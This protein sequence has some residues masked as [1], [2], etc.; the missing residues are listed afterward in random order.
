MG[1]HKSAAGDDGAAVLA[2]LQ[3]IYDVDSDSALARALGAKRSTVGAWRARNTVPSDVCIR[4][5]GEKK[6]SLHWLLGGIGEQTISAAGREAQ[7]RFLENIIRDPA[8]GAVTYTSERG[9]SALTRAG[10]QVAARAAEREIDLE[11]MQDC[12][13]ALAEHAAKSQR[14]PKPEKFA[15]VCIALYE[16]SK[17]S[18][19]M[20]PANS[21]RRLLEAID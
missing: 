8:V 6:L 15:R 16:M 17:Q 2:R 14:F 19:S 11:R 1:R 9:R 5:A 18:G 10:H 4:V 7:E 3:E 12:I 13:Q 21:V 20:P